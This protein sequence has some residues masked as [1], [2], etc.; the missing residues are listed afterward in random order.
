MNPARYI[1]TNVFGLDSQYVF[2]DILGY[3]QATISRFETGVAPI[4]A[5]AQRRIRQAAKDRG[6]KWD[7]NWFFEVPA[8]HKPYRKKIGP[9]RSLP[10]SW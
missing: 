3:K 7:N 1:R 4:S 9:P 10:S 2:A 6:L 5:G 8:K